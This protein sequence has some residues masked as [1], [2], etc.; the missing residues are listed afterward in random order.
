M[1]RLYRLVL[2]ALFTLPWLASA[3]T[4]EVTVDG[5]AKTYTFRSGD[6]LSSV[7]AQHLGSSAKWQELLAANKTAIKDPNRI[8]IGTVITIPTGE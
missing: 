6:T 2:V 1:V 8:P 7:A 5:S 4:V 3:Q